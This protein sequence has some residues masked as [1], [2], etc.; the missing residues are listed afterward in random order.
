MLATEVDPRSKA[1]AYGLRAGD[2]IVGLNRKTIRDLS[3]FR[4]ILQSDQ[5]LVLSI[6]RNGRFG[7]IAIR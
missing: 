4:D 3:E 2:V 5:R 6:Y 7:E 1:Y